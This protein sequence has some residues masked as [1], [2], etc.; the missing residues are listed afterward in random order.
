MP[1]KKKGS[2]GSADPKKTHN[3]KF[4][5]EARDEKRSIESM[6]RVWGKSLKSWAAPDKTLKGRKS[7]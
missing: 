7:V 5:P 6:V 3:K 4:S 1:K 2:S